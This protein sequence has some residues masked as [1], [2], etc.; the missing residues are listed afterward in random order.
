MPQLDRF[1]PEYRTLFEN[2]PAVLQVDLAKQHPLETAAM[3]RTAMA[4]SE[5][6]S[7][8]QLQWEDRTISTADGP[9]SVR[10]FRPAGGEGKGVLVNAHGGGWVAGSVPSDHARCAAMARAGG[11][12]VVA[13]EYRLAP[14]HA[15]PAGT[16]DVYAALCWVADQADALGFDRDRIAIGG[17]SA[18]GNIA[19]AC[20]LM[21][22]DRGGPAIVFQHLLSPVTDA[23]FNT[24][25]YREFG[26]GYAL[27]TN[28]MQ[29]MWDQ[30]AP[31]AVDRNNPYLAPLRAADLS[32]LPPALV[33]TAELDPLRDE[34]EAYVARLREAGVPTDHVRY[35]GV[36]H[37]FVTLGPAFARARTA[38]ADAAAALAQRLCEPLPRSTK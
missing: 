24:A 14:E 30:Y 11:F 15:F 13:V 25:S 6:K 22:R 33:Q 7:D 32:G 23:D 10:I 34:G 2:I 8:D 38:I 35:L 29:W 9:L 17:T 19:A 1:D 26:N 27:D 28:I 31:P 37:G 5:G 16:E 36:M 4:P 18:G 3:L 20:A 21:A 12:N